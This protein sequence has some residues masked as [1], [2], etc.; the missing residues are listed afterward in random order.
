[1]QLAFSLLDWFALSKE[2]TCRKDW[3]D[4]ARGGQKP[5][6]EPSVFSKRLPMMLSRRMSPASRYAVEC[7]LEL[8]ESHRVDAIVNASRYAETARGEKSLIALANDQEPSPTDFTMSV[9]NVAPGMLTIFRKLNIPV[10]SVAA[11]ANTFEAALFEVSAFLKDGKESVLLVDYE[12]LLPEILGSRLAPVKEPFAVAMILQEGNAL[13]A[14]AQNLSDTEPS[15][16]D[17]LQFL[18]GVLRPEAS[19]SVRSGCRQWAWRKAL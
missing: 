10:T 15:E 18:K 19:F 7:A 6:A 3:M 8:L 2:L 11:G 13:T 4:F 5:P 12:N 9:H 16:T 17:V 14:V 1:M